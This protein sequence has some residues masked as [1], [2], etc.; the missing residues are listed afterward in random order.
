[1]RLN[2]A[3]GVAQ[4]RVATAA[5]FNTK[6]YLKYYSDGHCQSKLV[7]KFHFLKI[8]VGNG[9]STGYVPVNPVPKI[10]AFL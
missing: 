5:Q 1:M 3:A 7:Q 2:R 6:V 4:I 10:N 8:R 9:F